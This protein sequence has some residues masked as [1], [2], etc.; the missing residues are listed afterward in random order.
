MTKE[1]KEK[2]ISIKG[3]DYVL[4][5]DRILYFN[6]TYP[7]G[8]IKTFREFD[9]ENNREIVRAMVI[10]DMKNPERYFTGHSQAKYEGV[11]NKE[12]GLENAESSAT[13]RALA[14]MWIGVIESI[15]SADEMR[16]AGIDNSWLAKFTDS[17]F[18]K[19]EANKGKYA[20]WDE[21]VTAI[22][23]KYVLDQLYE[24]KVRALYPN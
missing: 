21:A 15:A 22:K 6:E 12:A 24:A 3:K 9:A 8:C 18:D 11:V 20:N 2:A 17:V 1:L 23:T 7:N 16:K 5:K 13:W 14:M 10:P 19:F 4:V